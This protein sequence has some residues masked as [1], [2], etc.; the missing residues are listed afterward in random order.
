MVTGGFKGTA[1]FGPGEPNETSLTSAG[2]DG[3]FIARYNADGSLTWAKRAGGG[4]YVSG[5]EGVAVLAD[6]S[7]VVVG[8]FSETATFG[9]SEANETSLNSAGS[10]DVFIARYDTDGSLLWAKGAGGSDFD[11]GTSVTALS[12]NSLVVTGRLWGA[13]TFGSGEPN[14][15]TLTSA[16]DMDLDVFVARYDAN[17]FLVWARRA[18]GTDNEMGFDV[19]AL[20]NDSVVVTGY[21]WG[22]A[23]FGEGEANETSLT[24]AGNSDIFISR[25]HADGALAWAKR[26]GGSSVYGS[27]GKGVA[28]FSDDSVVVT[29]DFAETA[30]FGEP[31]SNTTDLRSAGYDD[32]FLARYNP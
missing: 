27:I 12:D 9:P 32:I 15:T 1:I 10:G 6:D 28:V 19:A 31:G 16:G 21:F 18:G 3:I 29:G 11:E 13:A 2:Y 17:G 20:S 14:E 8:Y 22:T 4:E 23:T 5:G 30:T 24:S 7:V 26:A 25:Y